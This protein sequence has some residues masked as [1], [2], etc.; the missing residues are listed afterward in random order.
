MSLRFEP[1]IICLITNG[2]G[3]DFDFAD[4]RRDI[5]DIVRIAV[6]ENISLVQIREKRLSARRIFELT[7]AA[8][9]ITRE[10]TTRLLVN[11]RADIALAAGADGVHLTAN[12]LPVAVIRK[13]FPEEFIIGVS[14][15]TLEAT[16]NAAQDGADFTVFAPVFETPGKGMAQGLLALSEVCERV[17]PFPVIGL[18]GIDES[19]CDSVIASGASGIAAIRSLNDAESL[20]AIAGKL[21]T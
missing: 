12:S 7:A 4:A 11:D 20:R 5:L 13:D 10:S 1:P 18:G 16:K 8:A 15:H 14:T 21:R 6:D 2:V 9:A 3:E 19:N 17:R